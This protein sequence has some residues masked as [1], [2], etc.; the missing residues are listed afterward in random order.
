MSGIDDEGVVRFSFD[1]EVV[2]APPDG[3]TAVYVQVTAPPLAAGE[4]SERY[5]TVRADRRTRPTTA[6]VPSCG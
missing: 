4:R 2:E 3:S 6:S 5:L 1:P